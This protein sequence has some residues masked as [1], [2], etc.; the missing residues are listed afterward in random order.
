MDQSEEKAVPSISSTMITELSED[1][2]EE[3]ALMAKALPGNIY[4]GTV[5]LDTLITI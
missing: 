2:T 1:S 5:P 4:L 3:A